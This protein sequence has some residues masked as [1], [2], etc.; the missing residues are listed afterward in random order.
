MVPS[1][2]LNF[3][4]FVQTGKKV[5]SVTDAERKI[6]SFLVDVF[7]DVL[8]LEEDDLAKGP[9]KNLSVSE[10]HVLDAVNCA[11]G[12]ETMRELAAR[13]RV[14]ASTLTVAVKTLEAKG[15]LVRRRPDEDRRKVIVGLTDS[16]RAAL[17]RH[18]A[19]HEQL[20]HQVSDRLTDRQMDQLA[21]PLRQIHG[22]FSNIQ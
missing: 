7:N 8:R 16:A 21:D 20:I 12:G 10:M 17:A 15:Y 2:R 5:H 14:T 11:A 18:A 1:I 22:F 19:F 6:N 9:Y 4:V 13:L 3:K